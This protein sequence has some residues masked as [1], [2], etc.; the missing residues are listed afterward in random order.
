ML[1]QESL[2]PSDVV[3]SRRLLGMGIYLE[4]PVGGSLSF[5]PELVQYSTCI[6]HE[7]SEN[8]LGFPFVG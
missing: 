8:E 6:L 2:D 3:V 4:T 7:A 5:V 1:S